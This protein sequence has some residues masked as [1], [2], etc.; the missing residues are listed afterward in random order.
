MPERSMRLAEQS[1]RA[2]SAKL[3]PYTPGS[4]PLSASSDPVARRAVRLLAM[5]HELHKAGYQRLRICAG[6]SVRRC[7][8][9][10]PI[11]VRVSAL[12]LTMS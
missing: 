5:V 10:I 12:S 8:R 3:E 11:S 2:Q 1:Q 4:V 7:A 6:Y 9:R